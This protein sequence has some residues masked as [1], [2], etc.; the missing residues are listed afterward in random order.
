MAPKSKSKVNV[1]AKPVKKASVPVK[2]KVKSA[3]RITLEELDAI[4]SDDDNDNGRSDGDEW[5]AEALALRKA[6]QEGAFDHLLQKQTNDDDDDEE[7]KEVTLDDDMKDDD[8]KDED[9]VDEAKELIPMEENPIDDDDI[10]DK[11]SQQ[12]D[13]PEEQDHSDAND[14]EQQLEPEPDW[15]NGK[16]L[17]TVTKQLEA[18]KNGMPWAESFCIIAKTPLPFGAGA[19]EGN[20]L[21]VHDDLKR[22]LAFYNMALEAANMARKKCEESNVPFTRPEDF[23]AE[24]LKTDGTFLLFFTALPITP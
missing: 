23:F 21:D 15:G 5:D 22:E 19:A 2:A 1:K 9:S 3:P 11:D 6:I 20:P 8:E 10:H 4:S 14:E 13:D 12:G 17:L 16:A 18:A 24:M 7:I